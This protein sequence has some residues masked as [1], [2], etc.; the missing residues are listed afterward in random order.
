MTPFE[1]RPRSWVTL[2][3][4]VGLVA[5]VWL[6]RL[7]LADWPDAAPDFRLIQEAWTVI[8]RHFV[9]RGK[10]SPKT[11]TY[12]ALSGM[13][14]AL[15]DTGHSRFLSPQ[16]V[17]E[18]RAIN[19]SR[20]EGIG[21]EVSMKNGHVVIVAPMP[22]S[23]AI[24][25]GLHSGDVILK[26]DGLD[27]AGLPLDQVVARISGRAGTEVTL[28]ILDHQ[29][30]Q[31][32]DVRITR[33]KVTIHAVTWERLSDG[34]FADVH[35]ASFDKGSSSELRKTL[36]TIKHEHLRGIVLDLRNNPGGLLD[37]AVGIASEFVGTGTVVEVKNSA[38]KIT[39][40]PVE[41]HGVAT[42][43]PL[44]VLVNEGSA[45]AAEI[46]AGALQDAQRGPL[47]G[48]KTFGT[49]TVLG[50]FPLDDGSALLLA[51][52]EW[53]T[54]NGHLIWHKGIAPDE[55]VALAPNELPVFPGGGTRPGNDAQLARAVDLLKKQGPR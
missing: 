4:A 37:E 1:N 52:E 36:E 20:F 32:R 51:V 15:G 44:V 49:G 13:M 40:V 26:V 17:K 7:A 21:A 45:S 55:I 19:R 8:H 14:D 25:A 53:L 38:G 29:T 34:S 22:D 28:T 46:V 10:L 24:R 9:G 2:A 3:L 12:G 18:L 16:M 39:R 5:G 27:V 23:P 54:P 42:N 50:E 31:T 6:D 35:L 11:I 48:E 30:G 43:V 47:V 33:A 41:P